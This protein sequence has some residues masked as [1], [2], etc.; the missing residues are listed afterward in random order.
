MD[1]AKGTKKRNRQYKPKRHKIQ[2]ESCQP[3]SAHFEGIY[4]SN[5]SN[6]TQQQRDFLK[7]RNNKARKYGLKASGGRDIAFAVSSEQ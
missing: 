2:V 5:S 4:K 6:Q 1:L 7:M 3:P